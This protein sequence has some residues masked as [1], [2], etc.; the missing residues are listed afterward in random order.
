MSDIISVEILH[1]YEN[2]SAIKDTSDYTTASYMFPALA[3]IY[4]GYMHWKQTTMTMF[5]YCNNQGGF[6][7]REI[8]ITNQSDNKK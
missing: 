5:T 2:K 4:C 1:L 6:S 8:Y 3:F 7:S